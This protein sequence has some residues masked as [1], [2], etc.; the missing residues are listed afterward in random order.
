ME[1]NS[2]IKCKMRDCISACRWCFLIPLVFGIVC[3]SFGFFQP[4]EYTGLLWQAGSVLIIFIALSALAMVQTHRLRLLIPLAF[5]M[6]CFGVGYYQD[7]SMLR[8][9]WLA[10]S[11]LIM[12]MG[13]SCLAIMVSQRRH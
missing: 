12:F 5:G 11:V 1:G 4:A 6:I 10:G 13:L 7:A 3:F 8:I 2:N 9:L